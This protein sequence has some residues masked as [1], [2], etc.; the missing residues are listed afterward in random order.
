[1]RL[2][3]DRVKQLLTDTDWNLA[4]IAERTGFN[5]S[6]YLHTVFAQKIGV[7]PGEFR[8]QAELASR[9]RFRLT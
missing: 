3:L 4:Q 5:Y 1:L 6:E 2:R 7:T 9:D 8:K